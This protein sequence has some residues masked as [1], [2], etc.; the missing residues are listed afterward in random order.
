MGGARG[1]M[2]EEVTGVSLG[3]VKYNTG[4]GEAK[5]FI[6]MTHGHEQWWEIA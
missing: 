6:C 2:D 4:N 5:E 1:R 3:D